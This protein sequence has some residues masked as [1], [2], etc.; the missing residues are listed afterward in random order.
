[1]GATQSRHAWPAVG[2]R[3][4]KI[5][6]CL[7]AECLPDIYLLILPAPSIALQEGWGV[8]TGCDIQSK[9]SLNIGL[10]CAGVCLPCLSY[11]RSGDS[12]S[13]SRKGGLN[14]FRLSLLTVKLTRW[15]TVSVKISHKVERDD[16]VIKAGGSWRMSCVVPNFRTPTRARLSTYRARWIFSRLISYRRRS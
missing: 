12:R 4:D 9:F 2:L 10:R 5:L 14:T 1:M 15:E 3:R 7:R 6:F 8:G 11:Y 16:P 13:P